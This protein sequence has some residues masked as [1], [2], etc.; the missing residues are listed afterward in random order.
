MRSNAKT[1][2]PAVGIVGAARMGL[3]LAHQIAVNG[4]DVVLLTTMEDRAKQ[5]REDGCVPDIL[6]ELKRMHERVQVTT[7][8]KEI[9]DKTTL[10]F[11]TI[12][13]Y[14]LTKVLDLLGAHLDGAHFI[15]HA[16]HSLYGEELL[17]TSQLIEDYTCVKQ[18][19][20]L[21]GPMH[22]SELLEK[23]PNVALIGSEF[24]EVVARARD[25]LGTSYIHLYG[26]NDIRGVEYAAALHQVV[27]L[28]IGMADGLEL[29]SATHAAF[30]AAGLHEITRV[31]VERGAQADSFYGL[32]G[33]GRLVDALQ[34]GESNYSLGLELMRSSDRETV[35]AAASVEAKGPEVV[36]QLMSWSQTRG[37]ELPFTEAVSQILSGEVDAE[38]QLRGLLLRRELFAQQMSTVKL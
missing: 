32:V 11:I 19:G 18:I 9:A 10:I 23:K 3:A 33:V 27:A 21:A 34:R 31:G 29:G 38:E 12:S 22:M 8:A 30:V 7:D 24:A 20:V 5:L 37:V 28:A 2:R 1:S 15:V 26:S 25:V 16:T 4:Y 6:P 35:L 13:D 36:A 17:R 14:L